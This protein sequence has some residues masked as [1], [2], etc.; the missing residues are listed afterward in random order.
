[1]ALLLVTKDVIV[2]LVEADIPPLIPILGYCGTGFGFDVFP[3]S[4]IS[5]LPFL[6]RAWI[7]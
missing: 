3:F 7:S 4:S 1:M 6:Q 5:I 2:P